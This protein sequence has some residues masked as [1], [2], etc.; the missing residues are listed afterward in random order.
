MRRNLRFQ[1]FVSGLVTGILFLI[2]HLFTLYIAYPSGFISMILT[3]ICPIGAQIYWIVQIWLSTG[4]FL[5]IL[6]LLCAAW[7]LLAISTLVFLRASREA[8]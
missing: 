4:T 8:T 3:L 5:N 1:A 7:V 2:L 6:T